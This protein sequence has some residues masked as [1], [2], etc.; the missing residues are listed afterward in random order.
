[1]KF[2][3]SIVGCKT[4][5]NG[6]PLGI[7]LGLQRGNVLTQGLHA[8]HSARQAATSKNGDLNLGHVEPT[9]MFGSVMEL[10]PL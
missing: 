10:N 1:M 3:T 4:P 8:L 7:T 5:R 9:P 2:D 6:T